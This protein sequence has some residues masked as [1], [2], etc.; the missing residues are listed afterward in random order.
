MVSKRRSDFSHKLLS[1]NV[2]QHLSLSRLRQ[3]ALAL[4]PDLGKHEYVKSL[5]FLRWVYLFMSPPPPPET[6]VP[7]A[8]ISA[9]RRTGGVLQEKLAAAKTPLRSNSV[10]GAPCRLRRLLVTPSSSPPPP[11]SS[12]PNV[13]QKKSRRTS[14]MGP[15]GVAQSREG[16]HSSSTASSS[17]GSPQNKKP[18]K[19]I[20]YGPRIDFLI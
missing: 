10:K 20:R 1:A 3:K 2:S 14:M 6:P 5:T 16:T 15:L 4:R 13:C 9:F 18:N 19:K 11:F 8:H 12:S 7:R 17:A